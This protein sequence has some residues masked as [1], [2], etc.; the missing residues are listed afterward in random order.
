MPVLATNSPNKLFDALA[1]GRPV[2]V[3]SDAW[4]RALVETHGVGR[5]ARPGSAESLAEAIL[6]LRYHPEERADMGRRARR[7]AEAEFDREKLAVRFE[8]V[9]RAAAGP[10]AAGTGPGSAAQPE[11]A[12]PESAL[13]GAPSE[14]TSPDR[15]FEAD[16]R[17]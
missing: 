8:A 2:I 12:L 1:A 10:S 13:S 5:F 6:W 4:T 3:N 16:V 14:I 17:R 9:L 11:A 15:L 7:L